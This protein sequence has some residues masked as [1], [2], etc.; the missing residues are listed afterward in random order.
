MTAAK[1]WSIHSMH[2]LLE[3]DA[4]TSPVKVQLVPHHSIPDYAK[5]IPDGS[6]EALRHAIIGEK[7]QGLY[8]NGFLP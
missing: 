2:D 8:K 7:G 6:M 1:A 5:A 4:N 3:F